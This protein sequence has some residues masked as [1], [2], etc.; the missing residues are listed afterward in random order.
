LTG[1]P[2]A[3]LRVKSGAAF[4]ELA[5]VKSAGALAGTAKHATIEQSLQKENVLSMLTS[6]AALH[7]PEEW[8]DM[9]DLLSRTIIPP[10]TMMAELQNC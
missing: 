6:L 7:T 1:L 3:L 5:A 9:A 10:T 8:R 2:F 4:R